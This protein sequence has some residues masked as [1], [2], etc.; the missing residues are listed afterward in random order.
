MQLVTLGIIPPAIVPSAISA[1]SSS[2]VVWWI[3]LRR[4]VD[5]AAQALDVGEVDELLGA[6]RLGDRRG[7]GV[8]VDVVGLAR[9]VG[10]DRRDDRDELVG[11]QPFEDARV[12]G[13]DV[14]DE[15]EVAV[16]RQSPA[17]GRRRRR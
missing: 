2:A 14:A 8:G 16:V 13:V 4:V 12:D 11:E 1:S 15:A 10:A 17:A 7:D 3:R 9:L 6:E 5:V